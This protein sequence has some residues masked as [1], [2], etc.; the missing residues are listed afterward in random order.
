MIIDFLI[1]G[2]KKII[3]WLIELLPEMDLTAPADSFSFLIDFKRVL[4]YMVGNLTANFF[5][6]AIL[7]LIVSIPTISLFKLI[8]K[9]IRG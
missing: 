3:L 8:I 4:N 2:I 9:V 6:G 1:N 7:V 5:I